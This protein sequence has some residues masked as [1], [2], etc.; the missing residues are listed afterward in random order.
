MRNTTGIQRRKRSQKI[1]GPTRNVKKRRRPEL[2]LKKK[3]QGISNIELG[4]A[5]GITTI[6]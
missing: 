3:K 6:K 4:L 2:S 1:R 5:G